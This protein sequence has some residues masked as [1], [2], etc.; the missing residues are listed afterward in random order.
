VQLQ[1]HSRPVRGPRHHVIPMT[2]EAVGGGWGK[3][4]RCV[5]SELA[6]TWALAS[7][8]LA[9]DSDC[10]IL[11][12]QRLSMTLHRENAACARLPA[13]LLG[14]LPCLR[15]FPLPPP[16]RPFSTLSPLP[17]P[18]LLSFPPFSFSLC[19]FFLLF[20]FPPLCRVR[21]ALPLGVGCVCLW[22]GG[23]PPFLSLFFS[24]LGVRLQV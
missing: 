20:S 16:S 7:G 18:P 21:L 12:Q 1:G 14:A 9:T 24:L 23:G 17:S 8:G 11:L 13:P 2:M 19:S 10:A 15:P 3:M 5:W 6:K 4:A 22:S